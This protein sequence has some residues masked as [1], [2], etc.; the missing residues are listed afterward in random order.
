MARKGVLSATVMGPISTAAMKMAGVIDRVVN[1]KPGESYL[2]LVSGPL[3]VAHVTD[4]MSLRDVCDQI[5]APLITAS[6][7]TLDRCLR[8]WGMAAPRIGVAGLNPH[9][10]GREDREEIAPGVRDAVAA[11]VRAEGPLSPDAVFRQCIE[12]RFDAVLAMFHDQGHI[13]IKTW[14]FSGNSAVIIG[15]PYVHLSVAHGTAYDI[16]GRGVADHS[17]MLSAMRTAGFLAAGRGFP[18]EG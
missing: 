17:M 13:A 15:P 7:C 10:M 2:F 1:V 6:L 4:H 12:G 9:A 3:R 8:E 18:K 5:K 16:A 14:G 11:G